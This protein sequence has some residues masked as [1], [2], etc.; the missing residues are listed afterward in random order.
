MSDGESPKFAS[1]P[2]LFEVVE[3]SV[4]L[5][6]VTSAW[7]G[8]VRRS[9]QVRLCTSGCMSDKNVLC[10]VVECFSLPDDGPGPKIRKNSERLCSLETVDVRVRVSSIL[11]L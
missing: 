5:R 10:F 11:E 6:L 3:W 2:F 7:L 4:Q 1:R 9:V 8:S